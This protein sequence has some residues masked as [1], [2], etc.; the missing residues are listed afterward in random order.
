M[1][2]EIRVRA[3]VDSYP[4]CSGKAEN[5]TGSP[6]NG[7]PASKSKSEAVKS[8]WNRLKKLQNL[9]RSILG[10][11]LRHW[12]RVS[13]SQSE[14]TATLP[15]APKQLIRWLLGELMAN[16]IINDR[17]SSLCTGPLVV[18]GIILLQA[19]PHAERGNWKRRLPKSVKGAP[20]LQR[21]Y[22]AF[23]QI[24]RTNSEAL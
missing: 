6:Q 9:I 19:V 23:L 4:L 24:N 5:S 20:A 7:H 22:R 11:L 13:W 2:S 8:S 18:S 16:F 10:C 15:T 17:Y 3:R 14:V 21:I 12:S 1:T